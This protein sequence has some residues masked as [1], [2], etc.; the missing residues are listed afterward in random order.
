MRLIINYYKDMWGVRQ[1]VPMFNRSIKLKDKWKYKG[2]EDNTNNWENEQNQKK[3]SLLDEVIVT[4]LQVTAA[5]VKGITWS[6]VN[7]VYTVNSIFHAG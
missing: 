6:N 3:N 5:F 4:N 7:D 2:I 1:R